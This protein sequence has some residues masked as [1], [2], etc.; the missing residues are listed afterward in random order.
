MDTLEEWRE[1]IN[2]GSL[3][4]EDVQ[5]DVVNISNGDRITTDNP[6]QYEKTVYLFGNCIFYG[7]GASD[8]KTIASIIQRKLIIPA[9]PYGLS[10]KVAAYPED[11]HRLCRT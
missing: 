6:E 7:L 2:R 10:I 5:S 8:D 4:I 11:F 3:D 9:N 1:Y